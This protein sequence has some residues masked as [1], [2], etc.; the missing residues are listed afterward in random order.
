MGVH[1][2][3]HL[4]H[5]RANEIIAWLKQETAKAKPPERPRPAVD[6]A[7][8]QVREDAGINPYW[9]QHVVMRYEMHEA[10]W[11]TDDGTLTNDAVEF[12]A[13]LAQIEF[14]MGH[15]FRRLRN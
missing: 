10:P 1:C 3:R 6:P 2:Y 8:G 4:S 13:Y 11:C 12:V 9:L 7:T 14:T 15:D 5:E